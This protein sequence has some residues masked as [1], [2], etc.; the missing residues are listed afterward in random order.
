MDRVTKIR[1]PEDVPFV[2]ILLFPLSMTHITNILVY[3]CRTIIALKFLTYVYL[4]ILPN[5]FP[6][7][8]TCQRNLM[9]VV[10]ILVNIYLENEHV[11]SKQII[12]GTRTTLVR[13]CKVNKVQLN[14]SL[15][16]MKYHAMKAYGGTDVQL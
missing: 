5:C 7:T 15:S 4:D 11:T 10:C 12:C 16:I 8:F 6:R 9:S 13:I 2:R 14:V 3:F 1:F